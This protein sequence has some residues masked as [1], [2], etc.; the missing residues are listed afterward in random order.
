MSSQTNGRL[1]HL[2]LAG[3]SLA[4]ISLVC[5]LPAA[6]FIGGVIL[7]TLCTYN[8][9]LIPQDIMGSWRVPAFLTSKLLGVFFALDSR[10]FPHIHTAS[11][12]YNTASE[13]EHPALH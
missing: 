10:R 9:V 11:L 1:A 7:T 6:S 8:R 12:P 4:Y 5:A 13:S 3:H 2:M